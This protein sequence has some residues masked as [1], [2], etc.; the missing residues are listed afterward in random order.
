MR[1]PECDYEVEDRGQ[2]GGKANCPPGVPCVDDQWPGFCCGTDSA[3]K[4]A[5][6]WFY[7]CQTCKKRVAVGGALAGWLAAWLTGRQAWCLH[8]ARQ[9]SAC[10]VPLRLAMPSPAGPRAAPPHPPLPAQSWQQCGGKQSC[11][12]NMT[13]ADS[14]WPDTCCP[15]GYQCQRQQ[16]FYW[17]CVPPGYING[18]NST[19]PPP[20]PMPINASAIPA[21]AP[22]PIATKPPPAA[23]AAN[24]SEP[25]ELNGSR[26]TNN[27]AA[28]VLEQLVA[29][30][31][32]PQASVVPDTPAPQVAT[33]EQPASGGKQGLG[34][35]GIV[36]IVIGAIAVVSLVALGSFMYF[37]RKQQRSQAAMMVRYPVLAS[38]GPA[39]GPTSPPGRRGLG[40][41]GRSGAGAPLLLALDA[42]PL[43]RLLRQPATRAP[44]RPIPRTSSPRPIPR[45]PAPP[46]G[47]QASSRPRAPPTCTTT[48]LTTPPSS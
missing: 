8:D 27:T 21:P 41:A 47:P 1:R 9:V 10:L 17:Q 35:G 36:G 23:P 29:N 43:H 31:K 48:S 18:T 2:C 5:H 46:P 40:S 6:K 24:L 32:N 42:A 45:P 39:R 44:P 37:K 16:E 7:Q 22:A 34:A 13:C 30:S 33:T 14:E 4:R 20:A 38:V 26:T 11:P 28:K 12:P 15:T 3:C 19:A 25:G